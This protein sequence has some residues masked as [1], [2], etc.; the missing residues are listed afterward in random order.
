[1]SIIKVFHLKHLNEQDHGELYH[2]ANVNVSELK[3]ACIYE[4]LAYAYRWTNDIHGSWSISPEQQPDG[5]PGDD[6]NKSVEII[7]PS[8]T[9]DGQAVALRSTSPGDVMVLEGAAYLVLP[10]GFEQKVDDDKLANLIKRG[11][12]I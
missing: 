2:V 12:Q 7:A 6:Y 1:M 11:L 3:E 10:F 9:L 5:T 4:K 8:T